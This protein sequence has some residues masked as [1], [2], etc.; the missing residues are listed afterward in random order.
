[1]Y[2]YVKKS[3]DLDEISSCGFT[4]IRFFVK[5]KNNI[6][7]GVFDVIE[8]KD[9]CFYLD[10]KPLPLISGSFHYWRVEK[11]LWK[12]I[13][14]KIIDLGF[15]II[16]TYCPW[17]V[18]EIERGSFDFGEIDEKKDLNSFLHLAKEKGIYVLV[19]P[20][21]H[22]NSELTYFGYPKRIFK[23]QD[24]LSRSSDGTPV[25]LPSPPRMFPVPSYASEKFYDEVKIFFDAICPIL[26]KN[27]YPRGPIIATQ[28]DNEM[29]LFFRTSPYDH[30]YSS[31]SIKLYQKFL[32]EKYKDINILNKIY[33]KNYKSFGNIKPPV[34]FLAEKK[35]DIPY[36]LD[37]MEYKEYYIIHGV[38]RIAQMLK[39][40]GINTPIYHNYPTIIPRPPFNLLKMEEVIDIQGCDLY[41]KKEAFDIIKL[42]GL[43]T[44]TLSRLPFMPEFSSG[45]FL[46]GGLPITLSD[47][48]FTTPSL[49]MF[50]IKAVN[51]YMLVERERWFGSPITR[52]AKIRKDYYKF[53]KDF[54][55]LLKKMDFT[56]LKRKS[57]ILVLLHFEYDRLQNASSLFTPISIDY[58][59]DLIGI[60][61]DWWVD[62]RSIGFKNIIQIEYQKI[63]KR[64][65][66]L[67]GENKYFFSI[68]STDLPVEKLQDYKLIFVPT[69]DFMNKSILQKLLEIKSTVVIG[70]QIPYLD[71]KMNTLNVFGKKSFSKI[72]ENLF[73]LNDK[74]IFLVKEMNSK[75]INY[76]CN[77]AKVKREFYCEDKDVETSLHYTFNR[78][79]IFVANK[80]NAKKQVKIVTDKEYKYIDLQ[81]NT[82]YSDEIEIE[83]MTIK[84]LEAK[85]VI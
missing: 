45:F 68:G 70:P 13:F 63:F 30:D 31:S 52:K 71:E 59:G 19:R 36:Y 39:E 2:Y 14:D 62:E 74:N 28:A 76:L 32:E 57:D 43:L 58:I 1:M 5:I 60:P 49:F 53:Y 18:H 75:I 4:F 81:S 47:Q 66:N 65:Y 41:P 69:F 51:F 77:S 15:K 80:S 35:E 26:E 73:K 64:I 25:Y 23:I 42:G 6:A 54:L 16:D 83:P 61:A 21:P 50:G 85:D 84:I 48:K 27:L 33:R 24:I 3:S 38:S 67:L 7:E 10:E 56:Q 82:G 34:D 55:L 9:N 8:I 79:I 29:S 12:S 37:W 46:W 44:S 20:G 17:S 78:K 22:I 40:R 11:K 72:E